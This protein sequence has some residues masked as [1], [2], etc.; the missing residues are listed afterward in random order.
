MVLSRK[1]AEKV[2]NTLFVDFSKEECKEYAYGSQLSRLLN[3]R[4]FVLPFAL[5]SFFF[6]TKFL[7]ANPF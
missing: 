5:L 6:F 4:S 3:F 2:C 1:F 7:I